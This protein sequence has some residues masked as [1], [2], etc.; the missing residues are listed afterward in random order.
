MRAIPA[1][2]GAVYEAVG[3]TS[4]I[5]RVSIVKLSSPFAQSI[6]LTVAVTYTE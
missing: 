6:E 2:S 4:S 3:S 5:D 1:L